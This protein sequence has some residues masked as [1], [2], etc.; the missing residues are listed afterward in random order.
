MELNLAEKFLLLVLKPNSPRY[1]VSE[2]QRNGSFISAILLD[3]KRYQHIDIVNQR[4]SVISRTTQLSLAHQQVLDT[5]NSSR[6]EKKLWAWFSR[7]MSKAKPYRYEILENLAAKRIVQIENKKFWF[8]KY[9][10]AYLLK[11]KAQQELLTQVKQAVHQRHHEDEDILSLLMLVKVCRAYKLLAEDK[12][13]VRQ[14]KKSLKER[15]VDDVM[16]QG[17][18]KGYKAVEAAASAA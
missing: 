13:Q 6:K 1:M 18:D 12:S 8:V 7:F 4:V 16:F 10:E 14:V 11:E 17:L 3:L 5:I 9:K 15:F 2:M